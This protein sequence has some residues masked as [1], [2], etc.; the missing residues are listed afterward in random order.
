[1]SA[2]TARGTSGKL[3][4]GSRR[5]T[6]S[7]RSI[8]GKLPLQTPPRIKATPL[9]WFFDSMQALGRGME[10]D[11]WIITREDPILVTGAS[12]FIGVRVVESL[13]EC[14]FRHLRC[15]VRSSGRSGKLEAIVRRGAGDACIEIVTGNLLSRDDCAAATRDVAV[16]YHLAAGRGEKLVAD[17]F[18][19]SVLTTR[20]LLEASLRHRSLKRFVNISS[21]AVYTNQQKPQRRLLDESCPVETH[22]G[23][24]G[25]AYSFAKVKQDE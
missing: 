25:D 23:K 9:C 24:R 6:A 8:G 20:N 15:F 11:D 2:G 19:N 18:M 5:T 13:M 21:F 16:I 22:P 7:S 17:A 10:R 12:G 3:S 14:G 4:D 1:M